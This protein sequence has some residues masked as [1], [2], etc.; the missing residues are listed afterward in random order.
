MRLLQQIVLKNKLIL[1]QGWIP[2]H[3]EFKVKNI[4]QA[5]YQEG[6]PGTI[7]DLQHQSLNDLFKDIFAKYKNLPAFN[8]MGTVMTYSELDKKSQH[9]AAF[10]QAELGLQKGER[11]LI[12]MPNIMQYPVAMIGIQRAGGVVVNANP[13]YTP[14]ELEHQLRDSGA[15]GIIVLDMFAHTAQEAIAEV[16]KGAKPGHEQVKHVIVTHMGDELGFP[17]SLLVDFVV[18]NVKKQV[19]KWNFNHYHSYNSCLKSGKKINKKGKHHGK[20]VSYQDPNLQLDDVAFLQYTGGTTGPSKGAEL[21]HRNLLSNIEQASSWLKPQLEQTPKGQQQ[22]VITA[23]PLYHI[24]SLMANCLC[25]MKF[26]GENVLITNPRD[27]PGFVKELK[28]HKFTFI[29][30][31]NTLFNALLNNK[32]F[33][34]LD[35]ESLQITL[36][37]GAAVQEKVANE[38]QKLTGKPLLQAY[39]L[40]ECSP[41]V[42]MPPLDS[43]GY[44]DSVGHPLPSTEITIRDIEN[45]KKKCGLNQPGELWVRG[46]QVMR[47]YWNK[48][49]E[50]NK[51]I[52]KKGWLKT[53]DIATLDDQGLLRIVDR[54]KDMIIV[55]G[56]N[57]YPNEIEEILM[58]IPDI[59]EVGV[60]GTPSDKTG[61]QVTACVVLKPD[62]ALAAK[63]E[64]DAKRVI[65]D[66]CDKNL[67]GYKKPRE[68]QFWKELPKSNIGKILRRKILDELLPKEK[69]NPSSTKPTTDHN[70]KSASAEIVMLNH[71]EV[72]DSDATKKMRKF[73]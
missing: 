65:M 42:S 73:S 59:L 45:L 49:E 46:P 32:D 67:T 17:K 26:G 72:S 44:T 18:Q 61:E 66:H 24:F 52:T 39:G 19:P 2:V 11:F 60:V 35:F 38:W 41:A 5:H 48:P 14:R 71:T 10:L 37:G 27:I 43:P 30:G 16:N 31:V 58:K 13:L 25:F 4:W 22:V 53:G 7:G 21:T 68:I 47:G 6:V 8:N 9:F 34:A 33:H 69:N 64:E 62:S 57:V 63:S 55:S 36:G 20:T 28:K 51:A 1:S 23:L 70:A 54:K 3:K 29:T 50:T 15:R 40:T 12:M 56:F